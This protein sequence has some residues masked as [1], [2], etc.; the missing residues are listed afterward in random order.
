MIG[1]RARREDQS[2]MWRQH[3]AHAA[4]RMVRYEVDAVTEEMSF[5]EVVDVLSEDLTANEM[6]RAGLARTTLAFL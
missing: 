5:L 3:D 6:L 1:E 4:G 2:A